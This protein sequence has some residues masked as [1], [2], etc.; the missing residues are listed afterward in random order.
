MKTLEHIDGDI[1]KIQGIQV[2][3]QQC[4]CQNTFGSGIAKTIHELHPA[5]YEAD[6][7][8]AR[9]KTNIL[10]NISIGDLKAD[11]IFEELAYIVNLYGQNLGTDYRKLYDRKTDYE[12]LFTALQKMAAFCNIVAIE[13]LFPT[14]AFPYKM[15]SDLAKGDWRI[16]ERLIEVAFDG[17]LG[18][19]LIVHYVAD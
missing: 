4:N 17:Y 1:F 2:I 13:D 5:A 10:G 14:V 12:A 9:E 11:D 8:A 18:K 16:V 15:G 6:T 3:G 7:R 19:V